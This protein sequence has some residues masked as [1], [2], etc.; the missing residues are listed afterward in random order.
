MQLFVRR[1]VN[2]QKRYLLPSRENHFDSVKE[3]LSKQGK[4]GDKVTEEAKKSLLEAI[5]LF[6]QECQRMGTL[7]EVLEEAGY[8]RRGEEWIPPQVIA[9]E[10]FEVAVA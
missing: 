1:R 7:E 4:L 9:S 6:L 10:Q 2:L 8:N 3:R 5:T